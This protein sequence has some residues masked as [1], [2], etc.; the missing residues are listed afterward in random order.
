MGEGGLQSCHVPTYTHHTTHIVYIQHRHTHTY[1]IIII[2]TLCS[3]LCL[4][5]SPSERQRQR[6]W[7][8]SCKCWVSFHYCCLHVC[9][10]SDLLLLLLLLPS[11]FIVT[12]R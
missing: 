1:I 10:Y 3:P 8:T 11:T 6:L 12:C 2:C 4:L 5:Q 7:A 9:Y